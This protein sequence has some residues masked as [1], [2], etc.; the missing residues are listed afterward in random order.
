MS[1]LNFVIR[2]LVDIWLAEVNYKFF[3]RVLTI[4]R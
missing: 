2:L 4:I 3:F 1:Q